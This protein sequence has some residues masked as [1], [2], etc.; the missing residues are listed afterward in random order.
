ML[1][2]VA[3][4][5]WKE[6]ERGLR[7]ECLLCDPNGYVQNFGIFRESGRLCHPS[8]CSVC[9]RIWLFFNKGKRTRTG[10]R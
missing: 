6:T 10:L 4:P 3:F 2:V 5:T 1:C 9:H 8:S 7:W